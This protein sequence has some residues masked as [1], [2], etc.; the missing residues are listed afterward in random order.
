M[1]SFPELVLPGTGTAKSTIL[2]TFESSLA[3][4]QPW[5][6][7][8]STRKTY[9]WVD[10]NPLLVALIFVVSILFQKSLENFQV[11]EVGSTA[12]HSFFWP[13]AV[14]ILKDGV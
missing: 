13:H 9:G 6:F 2:A 3:E 5:D 7:R 11:T 14:Q 8:N 12:T 4:V 10:M 1:S